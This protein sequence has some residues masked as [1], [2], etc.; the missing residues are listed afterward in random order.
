MARDAAALTRAL[1]PTRPVDDAS[2]WVHQDTDLWTV[3]LYTKDPTEL[4][5]L[6]RAFSRSPG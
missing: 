1:D 4:A 2:G 3:H 5:R 6:R